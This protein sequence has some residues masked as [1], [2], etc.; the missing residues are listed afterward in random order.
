MSTDA[1]ERGKRVVVPRGGKTYPLNSTRLTA[2]VVSR[3]AA[4]LGL[5]K[6]SLAASR[7]MVEG[8]LAEEREPRNVQMELVESE[9]SLTIRLRDAGGIFLEIPPEQ[10]DGEDTGEDAGKDGGRE[11]DGGVGQDGS[12]SLDGPGSGEPEGEGSAATEL[13]SARARMNELEA[14]LL[15][16]TKRN[17]ELVEEVRN[18]TD[19]LNEEKTKYNVLW[20]MNCDQLREYDEALAAKEEELLSLGARLASLEGAP[21]T[22]RGVTRSSTS[23][24]VTV[25]VRSTE[26]VLASSR[27]AIRIETKLLCL[28]H[29]ASEDQW[30]LKM[31]GEMG[32]VVRGEVRHRR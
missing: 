1:G 28:D 23:S 16:L 25:D 27:S 7:Q 14:E 4:T 10:R 30:S 3:I 11:K 29:L 32:L 2:S 24:P 20:R 9:G 8:S 31:M 22:V 19:K 5:P 26:A 15:Q 21:S 12:G 17:Q 13:E 6:A 18:V